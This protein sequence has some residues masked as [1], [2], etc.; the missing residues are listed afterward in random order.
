MKLESSELPTNISYLSPDFDREGVFGSVGAV[1]WVIDI[2]DEYF[3]SISHLIQTAPFLLD[4]YPRINFEVL[5]SRMH[6][7]D[8]HYL[9]CSSQSCKL[10]KP[11]LPHKLQELRGSTSNCKPG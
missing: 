11:A 1:V 3:N 4:N 8:S 6:G 2:Q 10:S 5:M 7:F 9:L